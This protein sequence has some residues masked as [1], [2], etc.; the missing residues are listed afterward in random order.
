MFLARDTKTHKKQ[1]GGTDLLECIH[2]LWPLSFIHY[3]FSQNAR[4]EARANYEDN[5][6]TFRS[7]NNFCD[8]WILLKAQ[9]NYTEDNLEKY[10]SG[11]EGNCNNS[12][13][14]PFE[15]GSLTQLRI[16][17]SKRMG[18]FE[19]TGYLLVSGMKGFS[20]QLL[21]VAL[22]SFQIWFIDNSQI[23]QFTTF[24]AYSKHV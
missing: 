8:I 14:F 23:L 20:L 24:F 6:I 16:I 10:L 19:S 7:P 5:T 3:G 18:I 17:L 1:I 9:Q 13:G 12:A 11:K 4:L 15:F 2:Y 21:W 22:P